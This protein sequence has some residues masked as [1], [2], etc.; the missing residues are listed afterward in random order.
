M[1]VCQ[2]IVTSLLFGHFLS[3]SAFFS[4]WLVNMAY[5]EN[6]SFGSF[7]L[8]ACF[9]GLGILSLIYAFSLL[10]SQQSINLELDRNKYAFLDKIHTT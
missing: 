9:H 8:V 2:C 5:Y 4:V 1:I 3:R 6:L 7:Q 10:S